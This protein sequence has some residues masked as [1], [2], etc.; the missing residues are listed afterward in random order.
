MNVS[1]DTAAAPAPDV[2]ADVATSHTVTEAERA[3]LA[4]E[5][6]AAAPAQT[7]APAAAEPDA[8]ALAAAAAVSAPAQP[9][10]DTPA[11][12]A[13]QP[14][15]P[16]PTAAPAGPVLLAVPQAPKDFDAEFA[17]LDARLESGEIDATQ[18]D[19]EFRALAIENA[20]YEGA[21]AS[22]EAHNAAK[23][24]EWQQQAT[25]NFD[26][27]AAGWCASNKEFMA[28]PLR[29][30]AFQQAINIVDAQTGGTLPA[31]ELLSR[32]ATMAFEAHGWNPAAHGAAPRIPTP[33]AAASALASRQ[34][35]IAA[36]PQT[37]GDAPNSGADTAP[38]RFAALENLGIQEMEAAIA[39]MSVAEQ[40]AWLREVDAPIR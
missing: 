16:A 27:A 19:K 33:G 25:T 28:N 26:E 21:K 29:A 36:V 11:A 20:R 22:V 9:S 35:P 14:N 40:D 23:A 8:A 32:A 24:Q 4:P 30:H 37:L 10:A 3:A 34:P 17:Q 6:S 5:P 2:L 1:D 38:A 12:A 31:Q 15:A 7:A 18:R 39:R 13:D